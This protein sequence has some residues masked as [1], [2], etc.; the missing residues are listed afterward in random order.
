MLLMHFYLFFY[1]IFACK[2]FLFFFYTK[3]K[4]LRVIVHNWIRH[5]LH[6]NPAN[7]HASLCHTKARERKMTPRRKIKQHKMS[8]VNHFNLTVHHPRFNEVSWAAS[9]RF[10]NERALGNLAAT[11]TFT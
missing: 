5:R 7:R 4:P 9:A 1:I 10:Y 6:V 11:V 3:C 2:F 8:A